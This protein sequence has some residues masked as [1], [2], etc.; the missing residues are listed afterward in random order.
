VD[1]LHKGTFPAQDS[2]LDFEYFVT[3]G[4]KLRNKKYK[5]VWLLEKNKLHIGIVNAYRRK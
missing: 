3:D 2:D 5:L 1:L 4:L